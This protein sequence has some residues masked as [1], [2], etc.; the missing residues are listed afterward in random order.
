MSAPKP[1]R[2]GKLRTSMPVPWPHSPRGRRVIVELLRGPLMREDVDRISGASN[3]PEVVYYL[4]RR[5]G[6]EIPCERV[7]GTDRDGRPCAPGRYS[8][9]R[10]DRAEVLRAQREVKAALKLRK[11]TT[12]GPSR[13][14]RASGPQN[15]R[16][17]R[18]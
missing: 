3:G 17:G 12:S 10:R 9:T 8:L 4:R 18:Q 15:K 14:K 1:E 11:A 16:K 5:M 7:H 6:L 13:R 2:T